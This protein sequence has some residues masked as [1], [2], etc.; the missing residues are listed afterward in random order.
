MAFL[1]DDILLAP[2]N[3]FKFV[4]RTLAKVAE[5]QYTDDAPLKEQLLELQVRLESGDITEDEYIEEEAAILRQLRE[6]QNRKREMAG[7]PREEAAGPLTGN[8]QP[9]SGAETTFEPAD[10]NLP[11][12]EIEAPQ[13]TY[14]GEAVDA[15]AAGAVTP[16]T[17]FSEPSAATAG[18][19]HAR[20]IKT[21]ARK[22]A[23]ARRA[24]R[25]KGRK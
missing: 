23:T 7:V 21:T 2:I 1:I 4:M 20:P 13:F 8:V 25:K 22:R 5:E 6:I 11:T 3:G 19:A 12:F 9:G 18:E 14:A 15:S 17:M 24:P 10:A 16:T